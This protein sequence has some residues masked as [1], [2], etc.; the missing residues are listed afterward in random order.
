MS[1]YPKQKEHL[2][3]PAPSAL[4]CDCGMDIYLP[5]SLCVQSWVAASDAATHLHE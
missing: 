4:Y 2:P 3:F 5:L 1:M